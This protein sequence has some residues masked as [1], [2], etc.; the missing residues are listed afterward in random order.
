MSQKYLLF[1]DEFH[2]VDAPIL[3]AS[4]RSFKFG[5]GLFES[6][7]MIDHKLQ[8]ADFHADRLIGGM[9][10]LKMDGHALM[11]DYFLRQ[12]TA[13]LV[14]K[15][16]WNG[17]VRFRLSVYREGA[18]VYT[19]EI[20]KAGYVL[21]GMPL[22]SN[23]YELNSKGLI[24][25]VYDEIAKPINKLS[26]YKT[27]NALPYVMAGIFKSQN[28]LDEAMILNQNGFLCESISANVFVVYNDQIYTPALTEGCVGGV[29]RSAV[30]Q[31]CKMND[32]ALV[33]AQ[34][35]PEILKEAE[36]VF[37]TNATQGIQWVMGYGRKR[38]FNEVSKFLIDKLNA[39]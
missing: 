33:E 23:Q 25:D 20:N 30:M 12:K 10:A 37:I 16:R 29:M 27:S 21:E 6:M 4:N 39:L 2:A 22:T 31:L 11:D 26:N 35:N 17:N 14:K 1:N 19:P 18:G 13:D 28:R 8:F 5:D 9:K 36:E 32:L 38:Y 24:I 34:I 7:R 3:T 15:N